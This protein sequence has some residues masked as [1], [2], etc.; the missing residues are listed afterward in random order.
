MSAPP[1]AAGPQGSNA[2]CADAGWRSFGWDNRGWALVRCAPCGAPVN[3]ELVRLRMGMR[4]GRPTCVTCYAAMLV[5]VE[6]QHVARMFQL[7]ESYLRGL[8]ELLL[9]PTGFQ[10][11]ISGE[12]VEYGYMYRRHGYSIAVTKASISTA[13]DRSG[14]WPIYTHAVTDMEMEDALAERRR[15]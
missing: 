15:P 6:Q 8:P 2:G 1:P 9:L 14:N 4:V 3:A 5:D 11:T 10:D 12:V 7:E 13:S